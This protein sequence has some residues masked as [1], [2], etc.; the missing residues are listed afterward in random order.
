MGNSI[1]R[2]SK[3]ASASL[4]LLLPALGAFAE[5]IRNPIQAQS[6]TEIINAIANFAIIIVTPISVIVILYAGTLFMFSGGDV[7]KV[8]KAKHALLW[9]VVGLGIVLTGRGLIYII[10]DVLRGGQ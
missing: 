4:F 10:Q 7:E 3:N 9:A 6:F 5:E 1:L 8:K 2:I